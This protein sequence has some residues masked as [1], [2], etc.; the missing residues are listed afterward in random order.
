MKISI[1]LNR[2]QAQFLAQIFNSASVEVPINRKQKIEYAILLET[3]NRIKRF[4]LGFGRAKIR[5]LNLRAYEADLVE[6]G[7][8]MVIAHGIFSMYENNLLLR[9]CSQINQQLA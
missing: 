8:M 5:T 6:K 3:E 4:A 2:L 1:K 7:L 9:I